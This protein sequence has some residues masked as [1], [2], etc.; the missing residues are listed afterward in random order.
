VS[1]ERLYDLLIS[2]RL[3][4]LFVVLSVPAI[5]GTFV[6]SQFDSSLRI[7][8]LDD[9]PDVVAYD[10][11]LERWESDEFVAVAVETDDVFHPDVLA[12]VERLSDAFAEIDGVRGVI[13]LS[14]AETVELIGITLRAGRLFQTPPTDEAE[15][16]ALR[17]RVHADRLLSDLVADGDGATLLLVEVAHFEDLGDKVTL[18]AAIRRAAAEVVPDRTVYFAGG[19]IVDDA[20]WRYTMKDIALFVP[21]VMLIIFL[22]TGF[23]F[24]SVWATL[25]VGLVIV[26]TLGSVTGLA[27]LVGAKMNMISSI[28]FPLV[29]AISV[30]DSV[31]LI[32]GYRERLHRGMAGPEA[33]KSAW[34]ELFLPCLITSI[35]TA[36]GLSSLLIA[37]LAPLRQFGW[38][39]ASGVGLA[40]FFSTM[41]VPIAFS[42]LPVPKVDTRHETRLMTRVLARVAHFSWNHSRKVLCAVL[43]IGVVAG[44]G[45]S[46]I[47]IGADFSRYFRDGDPVIV[48]S[49]FIDTQL[50]GTMGIE[51][52]VEAPDVREPEVLAAM[53]EV[54]D[55]FLTLDAID[56]TISP[57]TLVATLHERYFGDPE[58]YYVPDT[59]P[60][61]A[62]LLTMLEGSKLHEDRFATDYSVGRLTARAN[63]TGFA[64]L[65]DH[66][67]EGD[68]VVDRVFTG[69]ASGTITGLGRLFVNLD[70]YILDS[71]VKSFGLAFVAI[72]LLM[73]LLFRSLRIGVW[74]LL[75]NGLPLVIVLGVMGWVGFMLDV[76]TV[77]IASILIGLI[78]D[79][80]VHFLARYRLEERLAK[81]EGRGRDVREWLY[82]TGTGTGRALLTT[83]LILCCAF[84]I[85]VFASFEPNINFGLLS[86]AA[87]LIA[88]LC[89]LVVLPAVIKELPLQRSAEER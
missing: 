1:L 58:R 18:C 55:W 74:A 33:L 31:H 37:S 72:A 64:E 76:A 8:F 54:A 68:A 62:S 44:L 59:L 35:T 29:M 15:V 41:L 14:T 46:Q 3:K 45:L 81:Q 23:L 43:A 60:A 32:S 21:L 73:C 70:T 89:D 87:I 80:T 77:M 66:L 51:L 52:I 6:S 4:V 26:V 40:L 57:V 42:Y 34:C 69:G 25:V 17:R 24:R 67:H 71:Q 5:L 50:G 65:V 49:E 78:V 39:G 9:D 38:M 36:A 86:G 75:P 84:W 56:R 13:S 63:M 30:A 47:R 12:D 85:N 10:E 16:E 19:P 88:L 83:T 11:F 20:M 53:D 22:V 27:G 48:G 82:R 7:W 61:V 28:V 2:N 79:D